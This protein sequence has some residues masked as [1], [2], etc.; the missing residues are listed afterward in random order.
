M[1]TVLQD[2]RYGLRVM[3]KWPAFAAAA[4]LT[5]GLSIGINTA[6][7]SVVYAALVRPLPFAD[8]ER[9]VVAAA[10]NR[11]GGAAEVRGV[12]PADFVDWREQARA[13]DGLA[14][15]TGGGLTLAEGG[16]P[17]LIQGVR[18]SDDFFRVMGVAPAL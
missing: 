4:V 14:A 18:V 8:P 6:V 16:A 7:F 17:E 9:L 15:F 1:R 11:R 12:A 10:E 5:L 3:R 2:L 13:F